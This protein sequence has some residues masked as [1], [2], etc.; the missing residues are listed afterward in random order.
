MA[1][2]KLVKSKKETNQKTYT[3]YNLQQIVTPN[4]LQFCRKQVSV[5]RG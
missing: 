4:I 1:T 2:N 5:K 3:L